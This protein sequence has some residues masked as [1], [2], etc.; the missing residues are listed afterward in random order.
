VDYV[1]RLL[2]E[3]LSNVDKYFDRN[4]VLNSEG[5]KILGKV[6]ATL[7]TSEFKDKK[8]LKKVRREPT[9]ENVAKLV[10]AI[11]GSEAVKNLQK[12]GGAL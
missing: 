6:I 7:M 4:L 9:L 1:S 5:R 12:L 2:T 3:L 10:E 8:L 11:L